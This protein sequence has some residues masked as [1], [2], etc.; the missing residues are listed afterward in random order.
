MN[1]LAML[2]SGHLDKLGIQNTIAIHVYNIYM[3][4][5]QRNQ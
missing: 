1:L 5:A 4:R 3:L 2:V